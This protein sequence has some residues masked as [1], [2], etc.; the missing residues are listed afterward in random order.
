MALPSMFQ[1][2]K[3]FAQTCNQLLL[4]EAILSDKAS[5]QMNEWASSISPFFGR[6][7]RSDYWAVALCLRSPIS[8]HILKLDLTLQWIV[9]SGERCRQVFYDLYIQ[10][11]EQKIFCLLSWRR[12]HPLSGPMGMWSRPDQEQMAITKAVECRLTAMALSTHY[13]TTNI[14]Y[15]YD[16]YTDMTKGP[17]S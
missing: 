6:A 7:E 11:S 17:R 13:C 4:L 14:I 15:M 1:I 12:A 3:Q 16:I 2:V 5:E 9:W 8:D 10:E